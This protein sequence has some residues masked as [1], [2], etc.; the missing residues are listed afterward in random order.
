VMQ[1][2]TNEEIDVS[3]TWG[4]GPDVCVNIYYD[5]KKL[6]RWTKGFFPMDFTGDEAIEI[7]HK[8]IQAGEQAKE[9]DRCY[10]DYMKS[11]RKNENSE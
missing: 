11:E 1:L 7:G 10:E 3:C 5:H 8:L 9:L 4:D 6:D 2:K